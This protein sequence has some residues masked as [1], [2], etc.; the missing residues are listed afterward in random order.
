MMKIR[1]IKSKRLKINPKL[2][3]LCLLPL[4]I[5][6]TADNYLPN[7]A[8]ADMALAPWVEIPNAKRA[9]PGI[10]S[11][12]QPSKNQLLEAKDKGFKTIINLRPSS[13]TPG[14]D[15]A[16]TVN[17]LGM[18]YINIPVHGADGITRQNSQALIK[19]L[20]NKAHYP[21]MVHCASGSRVGALFALDAA[22][23]LNLSTPEALAIGRKAGMTRL[24]KRVRN[25]IKN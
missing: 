23:R 11:G 13:E 17:T 9:F 15:E 5:A 18:H 4:S 6:S 22:F 3:A 21:V 19:A 14:K 7:A 16:Q 25:Q 24:E 8:T 12:G 2:L 1:A 10:L 20:T